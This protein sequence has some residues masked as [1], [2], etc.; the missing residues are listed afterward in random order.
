MYLA[1]T[2]LVNNNITV[3]TRN[4]EIARPSGKMPASRG[5]DERLGGSEYNGKAFE[6]G[7]RCHNLIIR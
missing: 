3:E 1:P 7:S 4:G 2:V 5:L 6:T